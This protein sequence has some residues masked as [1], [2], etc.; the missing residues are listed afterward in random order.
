[1]LLLAAALIAIVPTAPLSGA[2]HAQCPRTTAQLAVQRDK[3]LVPR[4]LS[5]L[6][7][8]NLYKAVYR[9][10]GGCE[11]PVIVRYDIGRR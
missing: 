6:P 8:A 2:A 7:P 5:E 3:K 10:V 4:H 9:R 1:M 11:E